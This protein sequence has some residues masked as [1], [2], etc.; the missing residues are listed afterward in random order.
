[1]TLCNTIR[2][3]AHQIPFPTSVFINRFLLFNMLKLRLHVRVSVL[4][5][6]VNGD[7][8]TDSLRK[9]AEDGLRQV[10]VLLRHIAP[11]SIGTGGTEVRRRDDSGPSRKAVLGTSG[12]TSEL[13]ASPTTETTVEQRRTQC[14]SVRAIASAVEV[15]KS[16]STT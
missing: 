12:I 6:V 15:P 1:M 7:D 14:R 10:E 16:A 8:A 4:P 3:A 2:H 11:P 13:I 5:S 9:L